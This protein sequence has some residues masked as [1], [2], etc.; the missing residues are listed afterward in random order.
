[1]QYSCSVGPRRL[2]RLWCSDSRATATQLYQAVPASNAPLIDSRIYSSLKRFNMVLAQ[3]EVDLDNHDGIFYPGTVLSGRVTINISGGPKKLD[4]VKIAFKGQC[5]VKFDTQERRRRL[6]ATS[7]DNNSGDEYETVR[8]IHRGSEEYFSFRQFIY[9]DGSETFYLNPGL[10]QF[11]FQFTLPLNIP[12]SYEGQFGSIRYTIRAVISRPWRFNHEKVR[13]FTVN[14]P[15]DLNTEPNSLVS[16]S[17]L[18]K[19]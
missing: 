12:T 4:G 2:I 6:S 18:F 10:H 15:L 9:G 17:E 16:H 8:V 7:R 19:R 14:N 11:P 13:I 3:F 1:M 5:N